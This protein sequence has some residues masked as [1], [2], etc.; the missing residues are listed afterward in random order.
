MVNNTLYQE[1][2]KEEERV[3]N[4][5]KGIRSLLKFYQP[6]DEIDRLD[7]IAKEMEV[8]ITS[9]DVK[10]IHSNPVITKEMKL[11]DKILKLLIAIKK[12]M[13]PITISDQIKKVTNEII[14]IQDIYQVLLLLKSKNEVVVDDSN[15]VVKWKAIKYQL[16][17][18]I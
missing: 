8:H 17:N 14:G 10:T 7:E 2:L 6:E 13:A 5:L 16:N 11:E 4:V 3:S 15:G 12:P 9:D 1:L 18:K